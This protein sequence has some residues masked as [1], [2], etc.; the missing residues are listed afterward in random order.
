MNDFSHSSKDF[1]MRMATGEYILHFNINNI[2]YSYCLDV[3]SK[4]IDETQIP[5]IIFSIIHHKINPYIPFRGIP[6]VPYN[7]DAL[8]LVAKYNIWKEIDYWYDKENV[9]DGRIYENICNKYS[10]CHIEDV[11]AENF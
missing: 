1:G 10:W 4:K 11:L 5:V 7:I 9:A 8:Q 6:P 3:L 2:L